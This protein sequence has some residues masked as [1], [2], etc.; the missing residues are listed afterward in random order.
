MSTRAQAS[1]SNASGRATR[2]LRYAWR[3]VVVCLACLGALAAI[4]SVVPVTAWYGKALAGPWYDPEGEVLIVLGGSA[5]SEAFFG[6]DTYWRTVYAAAAYGQRPFR[7]VVVCGAGVARP[8]R[9]FLILAGVPEGA[10]QEESASRSTRENA[11]N[12]ARLLRAETGRKVLLTSDYHMFRAYRAFLKAG[13]AVE[14]RPFPDAIK[15][16]G[17]PAERW[18]V[19]L[20]EIEETLKIVYYGARGWL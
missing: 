10:I 15:R 13:L 20:Q 14:P 3:G 19:F 7:K 6:L 17:R 9:A 11:M 16:S 2:L 1:L 12:A 4:I 18:S 8:M 5:V